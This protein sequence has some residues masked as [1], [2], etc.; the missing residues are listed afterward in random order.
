MALFQA[1]FSQLASLEVTSEGCQTNL[2]EQLQ[3]TILLSSIQLGEKYE[4]LQS[5]KT[6]ETAA[7][8][9]KEESS[10]QER[11]ITE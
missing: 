5:L 7:G 1:G 10:L 8:E 4:K 11:K 6:E 9:E 2:W 3:A